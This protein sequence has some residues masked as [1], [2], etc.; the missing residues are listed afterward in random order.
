LAQVILAHSWCCWLNG[1]SSKSRMVNHPKRI[2]SKSRPKL[3]AASC[4]IVV[5]DDRC[6]IEPVC[7]HD[8]NRSRSRSRSR[9]AHVS[10]VRRGPVADRVAEFL[11]CS[12]TLHAVHATPRERDSASECVQ[13]DPAWSEA[14]TETSGTSCCSRPPSKRFRALSISAPGRGS[15]VSL[16]GVSNEIVDTQPCKKS[17]KSSLFGES[18]VRRHKS[19]RQPKL[20]DQTVLAVSA[21]R[22]GVELPIWKVMVKGH[23]HLQDVVRAWARVHAEVA[24]DLRARSSPDHPDL[25]LQAT[26]EQLRPNLQAK[27]GALSISL[28]RGSLGTCVERG[29]PG[30]AAEATIE[31]LRP[32][33]PAKND[34][35]SIS[36]ERGSRGTCVE[37]G[38]AGTA[39][40]STVEQLRPNFEAKNGGLS[41]SLERDSLGTR[42]ERGV[43]GTAAKATVEQLRPNFRAK[44]GGLSISLERD[45]LGTRVERG[46]A[47]TAAKATVEQLRPNFRA[48]NGGLSIS[49]ERDSLG[50]C[51]ERGVAGTA[52][53]ASKLSRLRPS[54]RYCNVNGPSMNYHNSRTRKAK[55]KAGFYRETDGLFKQQDKMEAMRT[56]STTEMTNEL[57]RREL[58]VFEDASSKELF[59]A[60]LCGPP[61][62]VRNWEATCEKFATLKIAGKSQ[63]V[64]I[65]YPVFIP[66]RGRART[67]H[68]NFE[69]AH[70]FGPNTSSGLHPVVCVVVEPSEEEAYRDAWRHALFLVLPQ[71]G[72]GPGFARWVIQKV[73]SRVHELVKP[74]GRF[75]NAAVWAVR[76]L[77]WVWI[78]DDYLTTFYRLVYLRAVVRSKSAW[79]ERLKQRVAVEGKPMFKDA[80]LAVQRHHFLPR[81]TLAGFLRDDGTAVCKKLDWKT[82]ELSLYKVV[83]LNIRGLKRL[84]IEY[85]PDLQ[86]FEDICLNHEVLQALGG[87]TLKCQLF[88][89]RAAHSRHG[90][91]GDSRD[92]RATNDR[93]T[94]VSDLI[95]PARFESLPKDRQQVVLELLE[96]VRGVERQSIHKSAAR[97]AEESANKTPFAC[98]KVA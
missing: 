50:A 14:R 77:P 13:S 90:G 75:S 10:L 21:S 66:S 5:H 91:C 39:A 63:D 72:R 12:R 25:D 34:G 56:P 24:S 61:S 47:G 78:V 9:S 57:C 55:N 97:S 17:L 41:I 42:V 3:V 95:H 23:Q 2:N 79:A 58:I 98:I 87:R 6:T 36:L 54:P 11:P 53:C 18:K 73:C 19:R 80:M 88:C 93:F 33:F 28:E 27:N 1:I 7:S 67:A 86:K 43:A 48:K 96:W 52:H 15:E 59:R 60:H 92:Q 44:N 94:Q 84:N 89:F 35:L 81:A 65:P 82:D 46:V 45:S 69:A 68:L 32:N 4:E 20:L 26:I 76:R 83:L 51:V 64:S 30:T 49:L 8:Q 29:V 31:Q 85:L 22:C 70:V 37:R 16:Q 38:V 40:E 74:A 62:L 71:S